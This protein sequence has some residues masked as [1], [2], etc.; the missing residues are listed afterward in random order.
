MKKRKG[1]KIGLVLIIL[2][3]VGG[4]IFLGVRTYKKVKEEMSY[5]PL[6]KR[7]SL[8][9]LSVKKIKSINIIKNEEKETEIIYQEEKKDIKKTWS[10]LK[11]Y[12]I[13]KK[14]SK[15]CYDTS[16]LYVLE[17]EDSPQVTIEFRCGQYIEKNEAYEKLSYLNTILGEEEKLETKI[18]KNLNIDCFIEINNS[19]INVVAISS[20]HDVKLANNIMRL[21]QEEYKDRVYVTV[22][23]K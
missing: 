14:T 12:K 17:V 7:E 22:N 4:S 2:L 16:T 19:E 1:K 3:L 5:T 13:G 18:K 9:D 8:K 6:L 15:Q 23:F 11:K 21:I 20:E 10:E